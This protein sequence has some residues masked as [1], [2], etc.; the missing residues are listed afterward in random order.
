M[1]EEN[2]ENAQIEGLR[3]SGD[4]V[5]QLNDKHFT[6][7]AEPVYEIVEL[8]NEP[9][10]R[11]L[12]IPVQLANGTKAEWVANKTSQKVI[13]S[14]RGRELK[15]WVNYKGEWVVKLQVIGQTGE[16]NVIYLK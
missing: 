2:K 9:N 10:T 8:K 13:V 12:V 11:R 5:A 3:I 1:T 7:Y 6:I 14:K 15:D 4:E 16:K